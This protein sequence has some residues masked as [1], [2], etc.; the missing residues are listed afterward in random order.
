MTRLYIS[1]AAVAPVLVLLS[2]VIGAP[3]I[4]VPVV[5]G[6]VGVVGFAE[7]RRRRANVRSLQDEREEAKADKVEF[8]PRDRR[9]LTS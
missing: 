4:A 7:L 2:F 9:T 1:V 5:L 6:A 3:F 8:T